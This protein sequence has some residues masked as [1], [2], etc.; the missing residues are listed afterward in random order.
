MS[1]ADDVFYRQFGAVLILL[2]IFA[3]ASYIVA[4]AVGDPAIAKIQQS[5]GALQERIAPVGSVATARMEQAA[6]PAAA[7][8]PAKAEAPKTAPAKAEAPKAEAPKAE[9]PKVA[10]AAPAAAPADDGA[11]RKTYMAACSACHMVGVA[12]APKLGDTA[13][14]S[15]RM[16]QGLEALYNSGINGKGQL[17]PG[18][19]GNASLSDDDVKAAVRFMLKESG[20]SAG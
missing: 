14:W 18:K 7:P 11:G 16:E 17:M 15:K 3:F 9:A 6:A 20:V 10:A 19:G 4:S 2:V 8:A 12:N 13:A 1:Q 5:P